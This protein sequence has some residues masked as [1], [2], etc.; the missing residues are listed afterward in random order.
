MYHTNRGATKPKSAP[1]EDT[2]KHNSSASRP[3]VW[4]RRRS[5]EPLD[6]PRVVVH[7]IL[8]RLSRVFRGNDVVAREIRDGS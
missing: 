2:A 4:I 6:L 7:A 8:E 1:G 3:E 5:S